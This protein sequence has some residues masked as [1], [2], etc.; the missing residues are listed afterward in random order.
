MV[1]NIT[2]SDFDFIYKLYMHPQV[3]PYLLYERMDAALFIPIYKDLLEK[4][5]IYVYQPEDELAGM[6]KIIHQQHRNSHVGYLGGLALHP[7]FAG[8]GYG[9]KMMAA[10][11]ELGKQ[12]GL[13]RMELSTAV[14]NDKAISLYEKI[15]FAKEG[16]LRKYTWLKSEN[17]F[18]DEVV[19]AY[20]YPEK[21]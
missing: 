5:I 17:R 12:M 2:A 19:M 9:L 10:I 11:I 15:G 6:F 20:L 13:M 8:K 16:V 18:L 4:N 3:N 14:T 7:S 1:R 21:N